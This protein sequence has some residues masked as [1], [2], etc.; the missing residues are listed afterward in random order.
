M[1]KINNKIYKNRVWI[2]AK[3]SIAKNKQNKLI[4]IKMK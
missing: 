4:K 1:S 2:T 3:F